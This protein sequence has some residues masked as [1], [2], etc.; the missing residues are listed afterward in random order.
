MSP[1]RCS[2]SPGLFSVNDRLLTVRASARPEHLFNRGYP[3]SSLSNAIS[4]TDELA[5]LVPAGKNPEHRAQ[6][7]CPEDAA[8]VSPAVSH[9]RRPSCCYSR[10]PT[11]TSR[12]RASLTFVTVIAALT[13]LI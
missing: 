8:P 5:V 7:N 1:Q 12:F 10:V 6:A 3:R 9:C 13:S 2:A 4:P 11:V